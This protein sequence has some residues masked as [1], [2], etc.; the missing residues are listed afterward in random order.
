MKT[1]D[2][3]FAEALEYIMR[4]KRVG[5]KFLPGNIYIQRNDPDMNAMNTEPYL[6][7]VT[8]TD[9]GDKG[10]LLVAPK[11]LKCEPWEPGR[12]SIFAKDWYVSNY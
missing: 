7:M 6:I 10:E 3:S 9:K 5:A 4:G 1:T 12:R 8:M 2:L 11:V